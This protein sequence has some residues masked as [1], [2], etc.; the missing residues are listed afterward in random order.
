MKV[1]W[2]GAVLVRLKILEQ[3][4]KKLDPQK[5]LSHT[6][7]DRRFGPLGPL[8]CECAQHRPTPRPSVE[9]ICRE[10]LFSDL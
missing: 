8:G 6:V 5:K 10:A 7:A 4:A 3:C 1:D 9:R 2:H